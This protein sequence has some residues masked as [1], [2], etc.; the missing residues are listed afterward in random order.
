[1][2][3][4]LMAID[5]GCTLCL[6]LLV[7]SFGGC[8]GRLWIAVAGPAGHA[9]PPLQFHSRPICRLWAVLIKFF[10]RGVVLGKLVYQER[11]SIHHVCP[12]RKMEVLET[13][14]DMAV[15]TARVCTERAPMRGLLQFLIRV[16]LGVAAHAELGPGYG[17]FAA[18]YH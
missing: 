7:R 6:H 2:H 8:A 9:I 12:Q 16:G 14:R 18:E 11:H 10:N 5:A 1:M 13:L 15:L 17:R 4:V 3:Q